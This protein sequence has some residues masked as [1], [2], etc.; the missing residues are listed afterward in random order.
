MLSP[1]VANAYTV[2]M[3]KTLIAVVTLFP[4]I[5]AVTLN[6]DAQTLA[7]LVG[8]CCQNFRLLMF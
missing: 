1:Y 4:H 6:E 3:Y 5:A 7:R 8:I 2:E